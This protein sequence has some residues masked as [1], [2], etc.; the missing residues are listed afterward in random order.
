M[1]SKLINLIGYWNGSEKDPEISFYVKE[2]EK[3]TRKLVHITLE[4]IEESSTDIKIDSE[5]KRASKNLKNL[6]KS[7]KHWE[8]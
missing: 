6:I 5:Y 1:V 7:V 4:L 2:S 3:D 8:K